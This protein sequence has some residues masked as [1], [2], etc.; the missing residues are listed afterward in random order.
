[1][2]RIKFALLGNPD[3]YCDDKSIVSNFS[4]KSLALLFFL[5]I[6]NDKKYTREY[7]ASILWPDSNKEASFSNLRYNLWK[8]NSCFKNNIGLEIIYTK[9]DKI[10][11]VNEFEYEVDIN[12]LKKI[13]NSNKLV[14]LERLSIIYKGEFLEGFYLK[15]CL[16]Y[17][18]WVFFERERIQRLYFSI[19][20]CLLKKYSE[21]KMYRKE[22]DLLEKMIKINPFNEE[23]YS[24]LIKIFIKKGEKSKALKYY[25][26]CI[27][28][29]RENLNISPKE[30]FKSLLDGIKNTRTIKK[31]IK[32]KNNIS[33]SHK[34]FKITIVCYENI[35]KDY[36]YLNQA[37]K[38]IY[39][40]FG[41]KILNLVNK[42]Y[43]IEIANLCIVFEDI[44][45]LESNNTKNKDISTIRILDSIQEFFKEISRNNVLYIEIHN[46]NFIDKVSKGVF[47]LIENF[48][49][50]KIIR[51][52]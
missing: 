41:K 33:F 44:V 36:Y 40:K 8:I 31:Q 29:F 20:K 25:N 10:G 17:N 22:I 45:D 13:S 7:L 28:V 52:K 21:N 46:F 23:L 2:T 26:R 4:S 50:I 3:I 5:T 47:K 42:R 27:N 48:E 24:K 12:Q 38:E 19:L 18:D 11:F 51:I 6:N 34:D 43:L 1:M 30:S 39:Y 15:K 32:D 49:N 16:E 37:L 9:N 14:N 35:N